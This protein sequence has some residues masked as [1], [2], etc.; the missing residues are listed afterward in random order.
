MAYAFRFYIRYLP[1]LF[2]CTA[3]VVLAQ[4]NTEALRRQSLDA[5]W[6]H[7][8]NAGVTYSGGN[9]E[10]LQV[11]GNWRIDFVHLPWYLFS[12]SNYQRSTQ[13]GRAFVNKGFAHLRL[14]RK[15]K[16]RLS[17][18][19]FGQREF[20]DFIQLKDRLLAGSGIR[21]ALHPSD[22][23]EER[24]LTIYLGL[25]GMYEFE[26]LEDEFLSKT[27]LWRS[28]NYFSIDW[29]KP[30]RWQVN[31]IGYYQQALTEATDYRLLMQ[32]NLDLQL[33]DHVAYRTNLNFRYDNQP[34]RDLQAH[35]V[36]V[37]NGLTLT[38]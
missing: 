12:V 16:P 4:V 38:W 17:G 11:S 22:R 27:R 21:I 2:V 23:Q 20:N 33:T 24:Q 14:I 8:L 3:T 36:E 26:A 1:L 13:G 37:M 34:P 10:F 28:T 29:R 19:L 32:G 30:K 9:S 6:H 25:G 31:W 35:D 7:Q 18:E 5:G 15:I